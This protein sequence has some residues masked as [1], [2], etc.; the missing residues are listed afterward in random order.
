VYSRAVVW[1]PWN[2]EC[3]EQCGIADGAIIYNQAPIR[4]GRRVTVSQGSHLCTGTHNYESEGFELIAR[5]IALGD[6]AWIC[7]DCFVGPGVN[8]GEGA[9]VG[10]RSVVMRD[11][12]AWTVCAGHP[13]RVIK[14]RNWRPA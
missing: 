9:V 6:H 2:L 11:V 4:L 14:Q 1:A 3:G 10:A 7:A 5:P 12:P 8:I 13:C